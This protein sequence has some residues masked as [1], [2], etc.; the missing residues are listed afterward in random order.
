MYVISL[1]VSVA[2]HTVSA[3]PAP[4]PFPSPTEPSSKS[5]RTSQPVAENLLKPITAPSSSN[6]QIPTEAMDEFPIYPGSKFLGSYAAG[7]GQ[8]LYLYGSNISFSGLISY[9]TGILK[10]RGDRIFEEPATHTFEIGRFRRETMAF[11]PGIT[12]KEYTWG[13]T[14]GYLDPRPGAN[15]T[16]FSTVIQI[17]LP[18]SDPIH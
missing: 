12:I 2:I 16:R 9:Y 10:S 5:N 18:P 8:R 14:L 3:Q 7:R 6:Q 4:K 1:L 11:R 15:P 17:V 13:E